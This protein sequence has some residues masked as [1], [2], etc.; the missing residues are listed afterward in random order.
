MPRPAIRDR[1]QDDPFIEVGRGRRRLEAR[2]QA[3]EPRRATELG[4]ARRALAQVVRAP[5][6]VG[7]GQ[8]IDEV[9]VDQAARD[10][11]VDRLVGVTVHTSYKT[12]RVRKVAGPLQVLSG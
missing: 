2:K 9:G 12:G 5:G 7:L 8:L 10:D 11:V 3:D 6:R 1:G 4:R